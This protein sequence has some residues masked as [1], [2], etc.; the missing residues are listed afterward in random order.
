MLRLVSF[1]VFA[2]ILIAFAMNC[3]DDVSGTTDVRFPHGDGGSADAG[4]G[5]TDAG[6][7]DAG[8]GDAGR[9][10][11]GPGDA[12]SVDAGET[13]A[14][15]PEDT[16]DAGA[17]DCGGGADTGDDSGQ[18]GCG[19]A[20]ATISGTTYAPSGIDPIPR[21]LVYVTAD[22]TTFS[23]PPA[24]VSCYACA[25]PTKAL[26][27][28]VSGADGTFT[29]SGPALDAGGSFTFVMDTGSFRHVVR[30][31]TVAP[32][33]PLSLTSAQTRFPGSS[34]GDDVAP[35]I[36]VAS[37]PS[38]KADVNDKLVRVLDSIG[39][40][41]DTVLPDRNG[42]AAS[43]DLFA[44]LA[45]PA[46]LAG[47][48][49][50]AIPCGVLGVF[51]VGSTLP[52][53][54]FA[55]LQAWL[56]SGGRLYASD[57]AYEVIA[58][59][60]T[61]GFTWAPGPAPHAGDDPADS[62]VGLDKLNPPVTSINGTVVD[63]DLLAWLQAIRVV[64][65]PATT[66]PI[67]ELRDQWGAIDA[68]STQTDARGKPL[69]VTFVTGNV[70]WYTGTTIG[71]SAAHPLTAQFDVVNDNG[72]RCGRAAFT[73]YHMQSTGSGGTL[74]PQERVL[75]YLLFQ[76]SRCVNSD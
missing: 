23:P 75:E 19:G 66:I 2:S 38:G 62:G 44:F 46:K 3:S 7:S 26:A 31:V 29:L 68:V 35:R 8:T 24:T 70:S 50:I 13:D 74:S 22:T 14:R 5:E 60:A 10:D 71:P 20:Q 76:L 39:V 34:S 52:S 73:S 61:A 17:A 64:T 40:K 72:Q 11:G 41:Y 69:G 32:C 30:H 67:V 49:I 21:V 6:L 33:T 53:A 59:T 1:L 58:K 42:K 48:D 51:T 54:S 57:L 65:A 15:Q 12:G 37:D 16:C 25:K 47:Y 4:E 27:T 9:T 45:D 56:K 18:S 63:A 36:M 28:A 55:N 43:G